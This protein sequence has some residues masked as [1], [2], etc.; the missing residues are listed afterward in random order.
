MQI[1]QEELGIIS[2]CEQGDAYSERKL[3]FSRES[4]YEVFILCKEPSEG[5]PWHY[6]Q[7]LSDSVYLLTLNDEVVYVGMTTKGLSRI[8]GHIREGRKKFDTAYLIPTLS[9]TLRAEEALLI[10]TYN[11]IHNKAINFDINA[12]ILQHYRDVC[13]DPKKSM[14]DFWGWFTKQEAEYSG[15]CEEPNGITN[16]VRSV[17]YPATSTISLFHA[18]SLMQFI[19]DMGY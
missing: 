4:L 11:P 5:E 8:V 7:D 17:C 12:T 16:S 10:Y 15:Y 19:C 14:W 18:P 9:Y 13:N 2:R 3:V 6:L 1:R